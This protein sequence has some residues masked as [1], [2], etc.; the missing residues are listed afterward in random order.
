[1]ETSMNDPSSGSDE[2]FESTDEN[3]SL[4]RALATIASLPQDQA[5]AVTLR[6]VA[7]LDVARVADMM[8]R[9]PGSVRVLTHRGLR[10]LAQWTGVRAVS[11]ER[12]GEL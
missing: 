1:M 6:I 9:S 12:T 8:G 3:M 4:E 11:S 10:R 2:T 5:E 7:G